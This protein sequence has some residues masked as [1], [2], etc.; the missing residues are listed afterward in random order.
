M[1]RAVTAAVMHKAKYSI[2][3]IA[4]FLGCTTDAATRLIGNQQRLERARDEEG[5]FYDAMARLQERGVFEDYP[6]GVHRPTMWG[7]NDPR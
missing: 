5:T 2:P 3:E 6:V 7:W 4:D 1:S